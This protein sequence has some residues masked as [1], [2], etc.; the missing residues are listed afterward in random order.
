MGVSNRPEDRSTLNMPRQT[1]VLP[2]AGRGA[3][4]CSESKAARR[5]IRRAASV[6][7]GVELGEPPPSDF[8]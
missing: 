8:R 1:G 5:T 4:R 6:R 3:L 2:V 7:C